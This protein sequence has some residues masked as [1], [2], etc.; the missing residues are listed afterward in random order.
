MKE[1]VG[2]GVGGVAQKAC[3]A[4]LGYDWDLDINTVL[5]AA[6]TTEF[7]TNVIAPTLS[8]SYLFTNP[9][10]AL[11]VFEYRGGI[12]ITPGCDIDSYTASLV[13]VTRAEQTKYSKDIKCE[14]AADC[15]CLNL[16]S[17]Y[18]V[19][20]SSSAEM[21]GGK[22]T[23]GQP[24]DKAFHKVE[25]NSAYVYDH[26]KVELNMAADK[27]K[28]CLPDGYQ[29]GVFYFPVSDRTPVT[30]YGCEI[31]PSSGTVLC[32]SGL[33]TEFGFGNLMIHS[34]DMSSMSSSVYVGQTV[35]AYP[36]ITKTGTTKMCLQYKVYKG[37][38]E[39]GQQIL[40]PIIKEISENQQYSNQRYEEGLPLW[41]NGVPSDLIGGAING[42]VKKIVIEG[43]SDNTLANALTVGITP[44]PNSISG[45]MNIRLTDADGDGQIIC[46]G[47]DTY[48]IDGSSAQ[49]LTSS[50]SGCKISRTIQ[51]GEISAILTKVGPSSSSTSD[52]ANY[53][54]KT[55]V[56]TYDITGTSGTT[57]NE[58]KMTL[59]IQALVPQTTTGLCSAGT[60]ISS[61]AGGEL[62]WPFMVYRTNPDPC[63][64]N[65][66][67]TTSSCMCGTTSCYS[68]S[69][70]SS[71]G[72]C[73]P[74]TTS[75]TT[76]GQTNILS[77]FGDIVVYTSDWKLVSK[78]ARGTLTAYT[79]DP[80]S[81]YI[82]SL[83]KPTST[84]NGYIGLIIDTPSTLCTYNKESLETDNNL[85]LYYY[86]DKPD[87][88]K[89]IQGNVV[90]ITMPIY[91]D[92]DSQNKIG[93]KTEYIYVSPTGTTTGVSL[94]GVCGPAT[95]T[96]QTGTC[97]DSCGTNPDNEIAS[98]KISDVN[99]KC[100]SPNKGPVKIFV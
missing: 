63:K 74:Q 10:T 59:L 66:V 58:A 71:D 3:M 64:T 70:C 5:D 40:G 68:G 92:Q 53:G 91:S 99:K 2:D 85:N 16:G 50:S 37:D 36:L 24:F 69:T 46:N 84:F 93:E 47:K 56:I 67:L 52:K 19:P 29:D 45:T 33:A 41:P 8:R 90:K 28:K 78:E 82:F 23:Q 44:S 7:A 79:L 25:D 21:Q 95:G 14:S 38:P 1:L 42:V 86:K 22:M 98:N 72:I 88:D 9:T 55:F 51:S 31:V 62:R 100:N 89:D 65:E 75:G 43:A 32:T 87:C 15:P 49:I 35:T 12:Y 97:K 6:Y 39:T 11:P 96:T 18:T 80:N 73:T 13:C 54:G 60:L 4:A 83:R 48:S 27:K 30:N 26:L 57:S 81:N 77:E 20:P 94:G 61:Q 34:M 17:S 76:G